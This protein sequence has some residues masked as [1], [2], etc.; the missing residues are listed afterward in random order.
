MTTLYRSRLSWLGLVGTACLA[1]ATPARAGW[2]VYAADFGGHAVAQLCTTDRGLVSMVPATVPD[3]LFGNLNAVGIAITPDGKSV[4]VPNNSEDN[5]VDQLAVT[6]GGTL[7]TN[8]PSK[9]HTPLDNPHA[10]AVSPDGKSVYVTDDGHHNATDTTPAHGVSQYDVGAGGALISKSPAS[11]AS[12][13]APVAI[14]MSPDGKS[15]YVANSGDNTISQYHVGNGGG[16]SAMT[17]TTVASGSGPSGIAVSADGKSVYV[18]DQNDSTMSEYDVGPGGALAP[19]S[20]PT[21]GTGPSPSAIAVSPDGKSVY[22]TNTGLGSVSQYE[23]GAGGALTAKAPAVVGA[24]SQPSAIAVSPD[25]KNV[26]VTDSIDGTITQY[27]VGAGG[28]LKKDSTVLPQPPAAGPDAIV[29]GPPV[30]CIFFTGGLVHITFLA[31]AASIHSALTFPANVGI[32]V[33]RIAGKRRLRIGRVPFGPERQ[34]RFRIRWN[35]R[36]NGHKLPSGRYLVTL[37]ALDMHRHVI[38]LAQPVTITVK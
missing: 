30:P 17:P 16:L 12:G 26:F 19:K 22:V 18:T 14:A 29:V 24:G 20:V 25:S 10:I 23:V 37:R 21:V 38:A 9:V 32:L 27:D 2:S 7:T 3:A 8:T 28:T 6:T 33:E 15:V 11:V 1:C 31:G 36:V 5:I 13:T 34:G 35:L 4:Y